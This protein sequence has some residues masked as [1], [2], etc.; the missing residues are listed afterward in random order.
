[1]NALPQPLIAKPIAH[2]TAYL[3]ANLKSQKKG[4]VPCH[5]RVLR[6]ACRLVVA[7]PLLKRHSACRPLAGGIPCKGTVGARGA[8]E[9]SGEARNVISRRDRAV[10]LIA[11]EHQTQIENVPG[12]QHG[13]DAA[14]VS[15]DRPPPRIGFAP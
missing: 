6:M 15:Q 8:T 5:L 9:Q 14:P 13:L 4:Y 12:R 7:A 1:M 11:A 2:L 10:R 3:W